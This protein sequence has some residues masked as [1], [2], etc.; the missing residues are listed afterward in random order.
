V[1]PNTTVT[2]SEKR[3]LVTQALWLERD[4]TPRQFFLMFLK[5]LMFSEWYK[6]SGLTLQSPKALAQNSNVS[7]SFIG[8]WP[9]MVVSFV[10]YVLHGILFQKRPVLSQLNTCYET[11]PPPLNYFFKFLTMLISSIPISTSSRTMPENT[12]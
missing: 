3:F 6:S 11:K 9:G 10:I 7:R 4:K 12:V 5:A 2:Q 1:G 8:L